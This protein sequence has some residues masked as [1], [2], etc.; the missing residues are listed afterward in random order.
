M[1]ARLNVSCSFPPEAP[2][3][4]PC[5]DC[6][7]LTGNFCDGSPHS[8]GYNGCFSVK[9]VPKDYPS[10]MYGGMYT[11]L[12]TYCETR[13]GYCRFC[14]GVA[15]CT[16]PNRNH[17][18]SGV[19]GSIGPSTAVSAYCTASEHAT[20]SGKSREVPS[21]VAQEVRGK[22]LVLTP[23]TVDVTAETPIMDRVDMEAP[24]ALAGEKLRL[25]KKKKS[26]DRK[27]RQRR[28][29]KRQGAAQ[30][31]GATSRTPPAEPT[32]E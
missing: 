31:S 23:S 8:V 28:L 19:S 21:V 12:C 25:R 3:S 1:T 14:R 29:E 17:H 27:M 15:S 9:R 26:R 22:L 20:G 4:F 32:V 11:P 30:G 13:F 7:L 6:G 24:D 10:E 18:W 5:V 2:T 16:P